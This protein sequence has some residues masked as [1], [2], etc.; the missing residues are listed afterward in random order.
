MQPFSFC[1]YYCSR[2]CQVSD[3]PCH[4]EYHKSLEKDKDKKASHDAQ[5]A[6]SYLEL[7]D[8]GAM[9][10]A[11]SCPG[12]TKDG[13]GMT[14]LLRAA[15][16]QKLRVVRKLMLGGADPTVSDG[17]GQTALH[18]AAFYGS[19]ELAQTL[20]QHGQA[21][22]VLCEAPGGETKACTWPAKWDILM[23]QR[24]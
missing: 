23:L 2:T 14:A 1:R 17:Q 10:E 5:L 16:D 18:Y 13:N 3:W 15:S 6:L 9:A 12:E 24:C 19:V 20:I 11:G 8:D 21:W 22:I 4:K 7:H